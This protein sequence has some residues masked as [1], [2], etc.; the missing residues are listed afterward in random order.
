MK[1]SQILRRKPERIWTARPVIK[2]CNLWRLMSNHQ[3]GCIAICDDDGTLLGVVAEKEI[4][5][6]ITKCGADAL[7]LPADSFMNAKPARCAPGD[8]LRSVKS[9]IT[10]RRA[11]HVLARIIH[12]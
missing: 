9:T 4:S 5:Q 10:H 6:A 11:R 3:V 8:D 2:L 12:E 1:I 7:D